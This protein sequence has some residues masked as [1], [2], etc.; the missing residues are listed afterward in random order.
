MHVSAGVD[1]TASWVADLNEATVAASCDGIQVQIN[2]GF[3]S[4]AEW[5]LSKFIPM[6]S[7]DD[8][9]GSEEVVAS[10]A[11]AYNQLLCAQD[12]V[13]TFKIESALA[14]DEPCCA[15]DWVI[16]E[17]ASQSVLADGLDFIQREDVVFVIGTVSPDLVHP[18]ADCNA[19]E[20]ACASVSFAGMACMPLW[21]YGGVLAQGC[22]PHPTLD[23][24]VGIGWCKVQ[25]TAEGVISGCDTSLATGCGDF[26]FSY[27]ALEGSGG[28]VSVATPPSTQAF[29]STLDA[30]AVDYEPTTA[31]IQS[32]EFAF[33]LFTGFQ[34][35]PYSLVAQ[36]DY[37]SDTVM[38]K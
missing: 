29:G 19:A 10:G 21:I 1:S 32:G 12:G 22:G 37:I 23:S 31:F 30:T 35:A 34:G 27:C 24:E 11:D 14:D 28:T 4:S 5:R 33:F 20:P 6:G 17:M 8:E 9:A 18:V 7:D 36:S 25:G 16:K 2:V 3:L 15:G 26:F 38:C 13:Y